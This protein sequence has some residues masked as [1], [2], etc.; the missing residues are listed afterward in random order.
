VEGFP[1][2]PNDLIHVPARRRAHNQSRFV[3][4][5]YTYYTGQQLELV[6]CCRVHPVSRRYRTVIPSV[7]I[8]RALA[9]CAKMTSCRYLRPSPLPRFVPARER[10]SHLPVVP[11]PTPMTG[12]TCD[13]IRKGSICCTVG[14]P[15]TA[16]LSGFWLD[17]SITS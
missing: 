4:Y 10:W 14:H 11:P 16:V 13:G 17:R 6:F 9:V 3:A 2:G 7:E 1:L 15:K 12:S 8:T 5:P